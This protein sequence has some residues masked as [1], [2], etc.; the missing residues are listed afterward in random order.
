MIANGGVRQ[1]SDTAMAARIL[2]AIG[3]TAQGHGCGRSTDPRQA[4]V[5]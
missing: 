4:P 1:G 2:A 3:V 5:S